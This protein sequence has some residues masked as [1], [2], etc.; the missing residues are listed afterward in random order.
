MIRLVADSGSTKTE[1]AL[2]SDDAPVSTFSTSGMNPSLMSEEE[3]IRL[4]QSELTSNLAEQKVDEVFFYGA[5]CRS[6]VVPR[7]GQLISDALQCQSVTVESDLLGAARALCGNEPGVVCILGTG[8]NSCVYD[9]SAIVNNVPPLGFI[10]GDEGSGAALGKRLL[11]DIFKHKI[12]EEVVGEF[13]HKIGLSLDEVIARVYRKPNANQFLASFAPF[14][15]SCLHIR[16]I[17]LMVINE[18][19]NFIVRNII[20]YPETYSLPVNFVGSIAF[21]FSNELKRAVGL[22]G[23]KLGKIN[24]YPITGLIEYHKL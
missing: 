20:Y 2:I 12:S 10:L 15:K 13:E 7:F 17:D 8:S 4:L 1:W 21:H 22:C 14:I 23:F 5:G 11:G 19:C 24:Q 6:S 18:F 9:G 3:L 16:G